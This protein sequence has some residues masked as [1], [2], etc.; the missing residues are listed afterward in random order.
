MSKADEQTTAPENFL[1]Q[2]VAEDQQAGKHPAPVTRFP[3]EPNG[4]LHIG[5]A[6]TI[7]L[8]FGIARDFGGRCHLRFDDTNPAKEEQRYIDAIKADIRWLGFDWGEHEYHASDYFDRLYAWAQLLIEHGYAYVDDQ[9]LEEMRATRGTVTSPGSASPYRDRTAQESLDLFARM[10]AGE[11]PDG[12]K[13]LRAKIDMASPNML[14]RDPVM[15]RI[16]H[17]EH[18]RTGRDWCIYPMYD[19]AHGQSDWIEGV[20]HSLC[21]LEFEAHRPLYNWFIE[22][23]DELGAAPAGVGHHPR[24]I[25]F[26][27]FNL[28]GTMMS[29]RNLLALVEE[30]KVNGWD[31]PRMPT[32]SGMRRRGYTAAALRSLVDTVGMSRRHKMIEIA[33]LENCVREDLNKAALRRSAVLDPIKV[34]ITNYPDDRVEMM[35]A[36]NNPED[37]SAGTRQVPFCK[38]LY[39]QREDFM[40]DAPRKFFRLSVGREVRLRYGYWITCTYVIKDE[41]GEVVELRC[42][43]DPQTRGGENPPPDAEG[44]VRKV[45]GTIHWVSARHAIDAEVRLYDRLFATDDPNDGK[46]DGRDWR[47]NLNPQSLR[48]ATAKI[49]PALADAEVG[50]PIQFERVGYFVKDADS[51]D[52]QFIFNRTSTLRDSWA[53]QAKK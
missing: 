18:P 9:T 32:I 29:K 47:E 1:R 33:L 21:S 11:F 10:K 24:Q 17:A 40:E 44:K 6:T 27:R 46:D 48:V 23:I 20:T 50:Q 8:N 15:Y 53:K 43:Y 52:D 31:D 49:E 30:G 37:E 42:T 39:I 36:V 16:L 38:E 45:K 35:E 22:K 19:F 12:A 28:S 34:V 5:H 51:A 13:V 3:P 2:I 26:G 14:L 4:F 41:A 25:E 7:L